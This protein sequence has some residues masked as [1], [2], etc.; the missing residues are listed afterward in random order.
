MPMNCKEEAFFLGS[1]A[2]M[3]IKHPP[4]HYLKRMYLDSVTYNAPAM[5]MVLDGARPRRLRQRRPAADLAQTARHQA[6]QGSR[7]PRGRARGD[8]LGQR[9]ATAQAPDC[10]RRGRVSSSS[11]AFDPAG[12]NQAPR[13]L[14]GSRVDEWAAHP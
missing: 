2:P 5:K 8:L 4:S 6:D 10:A 9:G 12:W 14:S 11:G 13:G 1:Y 3:K 7:P